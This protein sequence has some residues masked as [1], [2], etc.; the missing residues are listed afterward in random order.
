MPFGTRLKTWFGVV[1]LVASCLVCCNRTPPSES[2]FFVGDREG[3]DPKIRAL[4]GR[5]EARVRERPDAIET[6]GELCLAYEANT[7]WTE[8]AHCHRLAFS[9]DP[10]QP[11][12]RL[13]HA[14]CL[15]YLHDVE[16]AL[17]ILRDLSAR[18][19]ETAEIR[20]QH[21]ETA[22]L[23]GLLDEAEQ[24]FRSLIESHS[25]SPFG[26]VGLA[27][28][29]VRRSRFD[30]ARELVEKALELD[31]TFSGAQYI[32]G[33]AYRG[34][35]L[36]ERAR[37]ALEKGVGQRR[38]M[39]MDPLAERMT[40]Y[41]VTLP[42]RGQMYERYL[43]RGQ[44]DKAEQFLLDAMEVNPNAVSLQ[45]KLA[46]LYARQG[47]LSRA[48]G[49]LKAAVQMDASNAKGFRLLAQYLERDK[50]WAE[51][52]EAVRTSIRLD[53]SDAGAHAILGRLL[54]QQGR[55]DE[56]LQELNRAASGLL[57]AEPYVLI[58]DLYARRGAYLGGSPVL[59][60]GHTAP[61]RIV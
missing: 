31:A 56:A 18:Y 36:R 48:I 37:Q 28:I 12:W 54:L 20:Q 58:G 38:F 33:L 41:F 7:F 22:L 14:I 32:L 11:L 35:G 6:V 45:R 16:G 52:Y 17:D 29:E 55:A 4:F 61:S 3:L 10:E 60:R 43:A 51:A 19:P 15:K 2:S 8:A 47:Q 50:K 21:G 39:M 44:Y 46:R 1:A 59:S 49:V 53:P 13:H 57:R 26:Y 9:L 24:E 40:E 42:A 34:L 23:I 5:L 30:Q 27:D 25:T